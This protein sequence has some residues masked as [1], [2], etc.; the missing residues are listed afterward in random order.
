MT[1]IGELLSTCREI[2]GLTLREVATATGISNAFISQLERGKSGLS[3]ELAVKLCD[4]YGIKLDRLANAVRGS[5]VKAPEDHPELPLAIAVEQIAK[6][7][8][9]ESP[10]S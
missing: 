8:F 9:N 5:A 1:T 10:E 3:F 6:N 4:F 2:K 7:D